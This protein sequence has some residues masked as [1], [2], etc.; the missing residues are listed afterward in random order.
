LRHTRGTLF[1]EQEPPAG[2]SMGDYLL[3][4]ADHMGHSKGILLDRYVH[5]TK[6]IDLY[7]RT[8]KITEAAQ[9]QPCEKPDEVR[10]K[11][12]KLLKLGAP[13]G[14]VNVILDWLL[15]SMKK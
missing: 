5:R 9:Q 13:A 14:S 15:K 10:E 8:Y 7:G 6:A 12:M 11:V 3:A 2:I 4:V 1:F